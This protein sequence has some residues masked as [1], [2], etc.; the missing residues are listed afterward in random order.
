MT[1]AQQQEGLRQAGFTDEE[2]G[3]WTVG[4]TKKMLDAGFGMGEIESYFGKP[5]FDPEPVRAMI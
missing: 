2:I 1:G 3:A 5:P 4:T